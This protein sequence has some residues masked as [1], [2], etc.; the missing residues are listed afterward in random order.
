MLLTDLTITQ[1]Q[2]KIVVVIDYIRVYMVALKFYSEA[3]E[4]YKIYPIED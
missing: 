4:T 3:L 1:S 2:G